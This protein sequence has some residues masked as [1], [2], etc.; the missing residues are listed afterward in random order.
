MNI[1]Y[2]KVHDVAT[3]EKLRQ[4]RASGPIYR[5]SAHVF[6]FHIISFEPAG[7]N[8]CSSYMGFTL[9]KFLLS[10]FNIIWSFQDQYLQ[11]LNYLLSLDLPLLFLLP[12]QI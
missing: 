11:I 3:K 7:P 12:C 6:I 1:I 2:V 5:I 9:L 10:L 4:F 8:P